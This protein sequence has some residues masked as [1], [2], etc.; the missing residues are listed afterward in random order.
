VELDDVAD[1]LTACAKD[2]VAVLGWEAWLIDHAFDWDGKRPR[3]CPGFW[4]GLIPSATSSKTGAI[5]GE[6]ANRQSTEPWATFVG[7]SIAETQY[8]LSNF[9]MAREV[10]PAWQAYL[11]VNFT[12]H[13]EPIE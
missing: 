10:A 4:C 13:A 11:R 12:L 9:D 2:H 3:P 6:V 8:Q 5:G 1:F 7:R